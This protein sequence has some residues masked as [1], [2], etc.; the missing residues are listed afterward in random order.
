M[1]LLDDAK[2]TA[3]ALASDAADLAVGFADESTQVMS[4]V[5]A[6]AGD[7]LVDA[8][9]SVAGRLRRR[10]VAAVAVA[11]IATAVAAIL[12]RRRGRTADD[13]AHGETADEDQRV[14]TLPEALSA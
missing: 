11:L 2:T 9:D 12:G 13:V 7:L 1:E 10:V 6:E 4:R 3:T 5:A 14:E 8:V